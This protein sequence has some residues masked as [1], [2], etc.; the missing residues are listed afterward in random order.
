MLA[1]SP[2]AAGLFAG[3]ISESGG[4]FGPTRSPPQPGENVPR[5]QDAERDGSAFAQA[6]GA[7]SAVEMRK[8]SASAIQRTLTSAPRFWPV[9][10][11]WVIPGDQYELYQAGRYND[12]PILIG[13]NSD[14]G[15]LFPAP[16]NR[17]AYVTAVRERYGPFA[18]RLLALYPASAA[19][20]VQS[21]RDLTRDAAFGWHTWA[22]AHLQAE[23][24]KS[25]VFLYYFDH[26]PQRPPQ[27]PWKSAPGAVHSEEMI[28]V[29]EHL[30][31]VALP[32]TPTDQRLSAQMARYWTNFAKRGDPNEAGLP[33]WP[34]FTHDRQ[35]AMFFT[36]ASH[37]GKAPNLEKIAALDEYF[38]WRRTPE[39]A[40]WVKTHH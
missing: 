4:S 37:A 39:G 31:Q 20:W 16:D 25:K 33:S 34:A 27:S 36:D 12:T 28:Y 29:F 24:G 1:A 6:L 23:T 35:T 8:L 15:A 10:D 32:W 18:D 3:V 5:L 22:W 30:N 17:E 2:L 14:E 19:N 7:H 21:S 9:L 26:T 38:K 11:G 40:D 13:T